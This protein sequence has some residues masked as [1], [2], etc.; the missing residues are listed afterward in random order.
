M[1]R[2]NSD[3]EKK[4]SAMGLDSDAIKDINKIIDHQKVEEK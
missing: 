2:Y 1:D 4:K 3:K